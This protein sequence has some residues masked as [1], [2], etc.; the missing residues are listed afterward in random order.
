MQILLGVLL[1]YSL[2]KFLAGIFLGNYNNLSLYSVEFNKAT[3][4]SLGC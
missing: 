1:N 2:N 4:D 3:T